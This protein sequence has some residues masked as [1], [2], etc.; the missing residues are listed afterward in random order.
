MALLGRAHDAG[1]DV[2][3][4][5]VYLK[6]YTRPR[7]AR[8]GLATYFEFYNNRRVHQ[9]LDDQTPAEIYYQKGE[10]SIL[11]PPHSVS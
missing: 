11:F 4:E 8:Q 9:S 10:D 1:D 5:D 2:K 3:Y 7:D 6:G